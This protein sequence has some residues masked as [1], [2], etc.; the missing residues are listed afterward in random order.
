MVIVTVVFCVIAWGGIKL[1]VFWPAELRTIRLLQEKQAS[2]R[3]G[4]DSNGLIRYGRIRQGISF[5][6]FESIAREHGL[7]WRLDQD[8]RRRVLLTVSS[9][10]CMPRAIFQDDELYEVFL[11]CLN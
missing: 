5:A 11:G 8:N 9:P 2:G 4:I 7:K 1:F 10:I 3:Q 6:E